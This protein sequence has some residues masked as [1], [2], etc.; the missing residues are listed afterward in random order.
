MRWVTVVALLVL[1][2][3][4]AVADDS[5]EVTGE[6]NGRAF[7]GVVV[8]KDVDGGVEVRHTRRFE[9]QSIELLAG[10]GRRRGRT[11]EATVASDVGV[12]EVVERAGMPPTAAPTLKLV[13][14]TLED[15]KWRL[16]ILSGT[17]T[18]ATGNGAARPLPELHGS[19][20]RWLEVEGVPFVKGEGDP[21]EVHESDPRQGQLGDCYLIS[22]MI[23]LAHT[24][25][26]RA[27][28]RAMITERAPGEFVVS[29]RGEGQFLI[30]RKD[31]L[32]EKVDPRL[33]YDTRVNVDRRLPVDASGEL[34]FAGRADTAVVDSKTLHE[35][36]PNL[37]ERAYAQSAGSYEAIASGWT[38]DV[39]RIAGGD[40][41]RHKAASM[42]DAELD[43][44]LTKAL[45]GDHAIAVSS[46]EEPGPL[47]G[48]LSVVRDHAY[49]LMQARDGGYVLYNP[50]GAS[51]PTR[52][53]TAAELRAM[54]F[55][56]EVCEM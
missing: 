23:S 25:K 54:G 27:R 8:V 35:L 10:R 42:T 52:P 12:S 5:Y 16:R 53:L 40:V 33:I 31:R 51:H 37:I 14:E 20:R 3:V 7:W 29:L 13:F 6:A 46:G 41:H 22:G 39:F 11:I 1:T 15:E 21:T 17:R 32:T 47:A 19:A 55:T 50:W 56:I 18:V 48:S 4:P 28:L 9:D 24:E 45:R 34:V 2:V 43:A 36:W 49:A 30:T 38:G 44:V 26:G